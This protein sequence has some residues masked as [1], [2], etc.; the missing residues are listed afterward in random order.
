MKRRTFVPV[1]IAAALPFGPSFAQ[2][3][4]ENEF[5]EMHQGDVDAP[6]EILRITGDAIIRAKK[7]REIAT[8]Q[9]KQGKEGKRLALAMLK[10]AEGHAARGITRRS[11]P[12]QVSR[13]LNVFDLDPDGDLRYGKGDKGDQIAYCACGVSY[14]ASL[15]IASLD[16][17]TPLDKVKEASEQVS[18][19]YFLCDPAVAAIRIDAQRRKT[20]RD[21][22]QNVK[23]LPGWLIVYKFPTGNHIGIVKESGEKTLIT[24]EY[25]TK[26]DAGDQR[27]GGCVLVKTRTR[28]KSIKGYVALYES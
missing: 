26:G 21:E 13:Y 18:S 4:Q 12:D 6:V 8:T 25:N 24:V 16:D 1:T 3:V 20:W 17:K 10:V 11:A 15:A 2:N 28:D 9:A 19:Q 5:T 22:A 27:N 7:L 14:A 23:P